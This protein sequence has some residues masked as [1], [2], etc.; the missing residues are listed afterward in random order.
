MSVDDVGADSQD[1]EAKLFSANQRP[2]EHAKP[3][4]L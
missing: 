4:G 2:C 1:K 3:Q